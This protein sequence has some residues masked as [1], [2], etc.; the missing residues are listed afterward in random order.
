M[1]QGLCQ[2][3]PRECIMLMHFDGVLVLEEIWKGL[4][5]SKAQEG[6][7]CGGA[8]LGCCDELLA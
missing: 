6:G 5:F 3:L 1:V 7:R 4:T 8:V 2:R